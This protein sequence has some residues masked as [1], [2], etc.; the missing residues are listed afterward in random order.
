MRKLYMKRILKNSSGIQHIKSWVI[1]DHVEKRFRF[2]TLPGYAELF[3]HGIQVLAYPTGI[4]VNMTGARK[5]QLTWGC[6]TFVHDVSMMILT[7]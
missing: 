4:A 2:R 3:E 7:I 5:C 1:T 6:K